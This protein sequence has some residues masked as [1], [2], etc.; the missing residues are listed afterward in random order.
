MFMFFQSL[1]NFGISTI[2][3]DCKTVNVCKRSLTIISVRLLLCQTLT[4]KQ[5]NKQKGKQTNVNV[6]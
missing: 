1:R 3:P 2:K 5:T 4:N 6:K